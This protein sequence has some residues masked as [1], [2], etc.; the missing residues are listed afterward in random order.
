MLKFTLRQLEYAVQTADSGSVAAAA[1]ILRVAQPSIS[2]AL[3]KLEDTIGLQIF[4]RQHARG[5]TPTSGGVAFLAD[6]R[7]L[8]AQS[9]ELAK[10]SDSQIGP[11]KGR[12]QVGSFVTLAPTYAPILISKFNMLYPDVE[13]VF[14]EG[15]QSELLSGLRNGQHDVALI[16]DVDLPADIEA[17]EVASLKPYVLL[18]ASHRLARFK[19]NSFC[20]TS[21]QA[22]HIFYAC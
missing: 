12:L 1:E 4:I 11:L 3:K 21:N 22:E 14:E 15:V 8:L 5:L 2:A 18:S 7:R 10:Q 16:Y 20:S 19:R 13:I 17:K 6:A 9:E